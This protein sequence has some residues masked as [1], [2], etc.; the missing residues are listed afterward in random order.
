MFFDSL[1]CYKCH[2]TNLNKKA[3]IN[4][5]NKKDDNHCNICIKSSKNWGTHPERITEIKPFL[6][7]SNC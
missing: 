3:T 1:L 7:R 4:P 6:G 2:K 5:I